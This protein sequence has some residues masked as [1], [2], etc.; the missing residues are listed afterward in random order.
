MRRVCVFT[1]SRADYGPLLALIRALDDDTEIDL[2]LLVTG[3]HLVDGQGLTVQQIEADG[4]QVAE[5]V[6]MVLASDTASAVAKSFGLGVIG[7]ADALARIDPDILVVLGDRYEAL[8]V[9]IT[10]ALR[11]IPIAHIGGGELSYGS[12]D[13]S[14][15]HAIT[16]LAHLHLTSNEEFRRRVIQMGE[17]PDR[18]HATGAPGL[19][20][21]RTLSYM[22]RAELASMLGIELREPLI[23]VTYHP[24]TADPEGSREG[25]QGLLKAV[26]R[27]PDST[28]VF[29]GTNVDQGG[30]D[31]FAPVREY[32]ARNSGRVVVM[33]SLGQAAYLSL[34][35]H[36]A[37]VVGNS[38]SGLAE[39]PALKT[40]TVNIG[41]RQDGRPKAASVIDCGETAAEIESAIIM[42]VESTHREATAR[43]TSPFGDGHSAEAITRLLSAVDIS[44][45]SNKIFHDAPA[46][47]EPW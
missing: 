37:V 10:A 6:E 29:T 5:R 47:Q 19:D 44:L 13:D 34:V 24:A 41:S 42:A 4:F 21:I 7:Y 31:V 23:A 35:K 46:A 43:A 36:A 26:D 11:L 20:T 1:G 14:V 27:I 28:V 16:K 45:I 33:P 30:H 8:A 38:S 18:V 25:I 9:A 15:R 40:P 12:T 39:A 32:V 3:G 17:S 22:D 2:R